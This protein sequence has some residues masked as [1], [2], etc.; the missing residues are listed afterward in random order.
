MSDDEAKKRDNLWNKVC[1]AHPNL[2]NA[3]RVD[4]LNVG[5][6]AQLLIAY[7]DAIREDERTISAKCEKQLSDALET[8]DKNDIGEKVSDLL[9]N[10]DW[11]DT[12]FKSNNPDEALLFHTKNIKR[13]TL[14]IWKEVGKSLKAYDKYKKNLAERSEEKK[15]VKE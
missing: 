12:Y 3:I 14:E 7:E 6:W 13:I 1:D 9:D 2:S 4:I 10:N 8:L 5:R 15:E 11:L